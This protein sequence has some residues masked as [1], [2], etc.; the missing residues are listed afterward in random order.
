MFVVDV[1][2]QGQYWRSTS[3]CANGG[4]QGSSVAAMDQGSVMMCVM[5]C[6]YAE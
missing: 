4:A 6:I 2:G 3:R 5:S 1:S